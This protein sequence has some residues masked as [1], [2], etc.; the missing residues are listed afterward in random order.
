VSCNNNSC[1]S[2]ARACPLAIVAAIAFVAALL[3][4]CGPRPAAPDAATTAETQSVAAAA[5]PERLSAEEFL[6]HVRPGDQVV[7]VRTPAEFAGGHLQGAR[8]ADV[9][10]PDFEQAVAGL[11]RTLPTYVYCRSGSRSQRAAEAMRA[12]GFT[13]VVNVGGF[14]QLAR[15]GAPVAPAE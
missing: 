11:D 14:E 2:R 15:A 8:L 3:S 5:A 1:S 13:H 7:D 4:A 9:T 12:M 6:A 10:A